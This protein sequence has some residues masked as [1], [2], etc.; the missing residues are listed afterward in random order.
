V[1]AVQR[2]KGLEPVERT[3]FIEDLDMGLKRGRTDE[4]AGTAHTACFALARCGAVSVPMKKH[5]S[6]EVA[7]RHNA[8]R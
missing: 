8:R 4:H 5:G 1:R 2:S 7:A 6:P 3:L